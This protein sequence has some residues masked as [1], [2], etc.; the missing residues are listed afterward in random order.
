MHEI[1]HKF[2]IHVLIAILEH[3]FLFAR[4]SDGNN[5]FTPYHLCRSFTDI[6]RQTLKSTFQVASDDGIFFVGNWNSKRNRLFISLRKNHRWRRRNKISQKSIRLSENVLRFP[7]Q[8]QNAIERTPRVKFGRKGRDLFDVTNFAFGKSE[9]LFKFMGFEPARRI[10]QK[11]FRPI[12]LG[13]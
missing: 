10:F 2:R 1:C 3:A 4:P 5:V 11:L 12:G 9:K 8:L 7:H 6:N 13:V